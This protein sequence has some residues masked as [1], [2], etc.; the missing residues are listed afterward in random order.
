[1]WEHCLKGLESDP[2]SLDRECDWVA[3]YRL[4]EQVPRAAT[5]CP[6]PTPR[7]P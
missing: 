1:M 6:W 4:I 5:A 3:K 7:W 2:L